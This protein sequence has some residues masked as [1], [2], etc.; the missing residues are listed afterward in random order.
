MKNLL[1]IVT[2]LLILSANGQEKSYLQ[3]ENNSKKTKQILKDSLKI[4]IEE[5]EEVN[6]RINEKISLGLSL[7]FNGSLEKLKTA[8]ISPLDSTLIITNAQPVSFMLSSTISVPITFKELKAYRLLNN[9]GDEVAQVHRVAAISLIAVVNLA[10]VQGSEV[11]SIFNQKISGGLGIAYNFDENFSVGLSYEL[12]SYRKPKDFLL[13]E[14]GNT[15]K[16]NGQTL[17]ALDIEDNN[18]YYD[19]YASTLSLK[20]IYKLTTK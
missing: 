3:I 1:L 6:G 9:K 18:F 7:G 12:V 4:E 19:K 16:A 11:G 20:F 15:I 5:K 10:M 14:E 17:A 2:L 13:A 8:Q